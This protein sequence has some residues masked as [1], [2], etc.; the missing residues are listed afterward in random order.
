MPSHCTYCK[1]A[2]YLYRANWCQS[3]SK[4][5]APKYTVK[6]SAHDIQNPDQQAVNDDTAHYEIFHLRL[7]AIAAQNSQDIIQCQ[8][9][10]YQTR[11]TT[12]L[13]D[14]GIIHKISVAE[15]L[16]WR[17]KFKRPIHLPKRPMLF[18]SCLCE[19]MIYA[20]CVNRFRRTDGS[21]KL[22]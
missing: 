16:I 12:C 17:Q 21:Q 1:L 18:V 10:L 8:E 14:H 3:L 9:P 5:I 2:S 22:P 7:Y 11:I 13:N 20:Q 19:P 4:Y 6:K 15:W